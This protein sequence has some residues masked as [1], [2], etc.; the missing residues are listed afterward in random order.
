VFLGDDVGDDES[1]SR[2]RD[3][4]RLVASR[5]GGQEARFLTYREGYRRRGGAREFD[6]RGR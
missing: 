2:R 4:K 1:Y 5:G 3:G 6:K